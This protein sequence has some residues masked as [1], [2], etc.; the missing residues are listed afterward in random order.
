MCSSYPFPIS[1]VILTA[2]LFKEGLIGGTIKSYL[3]A[4]R[5]PQISL[6]LGDPQMG[7]MP[8]LE[9][10]IKGIKRSTA[11][12]T[13][14]RLPITPD[15]L[16]KLKQVWQPSPDSHDTSMLW[17]AACMYFFGFLRVGE[18]VAPGISKFDSSTNLCAGDVR[19]D[20]C[21]NPQYLE[22]HIKASK[23][24]PFRQGVLVNL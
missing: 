7:D 6:G 16:L 5:H 17:V 4:V 13:R 23:T 22:V 21:A 3:V 20:N 2:Y 11:H 18:V 15:I 10:V 1:E 8:R 24:D 9:Y 19:V 14:K 12:P